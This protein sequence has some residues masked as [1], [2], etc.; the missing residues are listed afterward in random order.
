MEKGLSRDEIHSDLCTMLSAFSAYCKAHNLCFYLVGGT[1]LGAVR[2]EGF[3]PW[4]DDIDVG[5]PRPDYERFLT[6]TKTEPVG[7]CYEVLSDRE[8]TLSLPFAELLHKNIRIERPTEAYIESDVHVHNLFL[9]IFP[10]DG[11]PSDDKAAEKLFRK[12]KRLR[13]LSTC[14]RARFFRGTSFLRT[15][16]KT[17][18]VC[19]GHILTTGRILKKMQTIATKLPFNTSEYVGCVTYG[20]YGV[21]ERCFRNEVLKIAEVTFEGE[22]YPAPGCYDG[23]LRG[24]YGDYRK[25]PPEEKR[26]SHELVAWKI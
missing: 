13:Y 23:Y 5:M 22:T 21:G 18:A 8:G 12:M 16:L 1:L 9:D 14:S 11:W 19:L 25:L 15:L 26:K 7:D 4:D 24:I 10:Q 3:I 6:L 20:I 2:H 17:P